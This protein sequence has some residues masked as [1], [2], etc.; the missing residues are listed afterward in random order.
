M[1]P[2][3]E[4]EKNEKSNRAIKLRFKI[5]TAPYTALIHHS[6]MAGFFLYSAPKAATVADFR[7]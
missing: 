1:G 3:H 6:E 2:Y 4:P 7:N 5:N